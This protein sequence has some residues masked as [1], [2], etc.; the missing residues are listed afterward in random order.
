MT[1]PQHKSG[2]FM[3]K[4]IKRTAFDSVANATQPQKPQPKTIL[5]QIIRKL[6]NEDK[7]EVFDDGSLQIDMEGMEY[8]WNKA[9]AKTLK[10]CH[11]QLIVYGYSEVM[12][13][14]EAELKKVAK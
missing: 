2:L 13:W 8:I 9:R 4:Q 10:E 5:R 6:E 3:T 11:K 7:V 12:K 1:Q 14:L